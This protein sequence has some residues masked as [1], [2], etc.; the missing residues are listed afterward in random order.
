MS[1]N[2][3]F[4][5]NPA[6]AGQMI[7]GGQ[8]NYEIGSNLAFVRE[9]F[10]AT[11][12]DTDE[13]FTQI[14]GSAATGAS[15]AIYLSAGNLCMELAAATGGQLRVCSKRNFAIPFR[16]IAYISA[17]SGWGGTGSEFLFQVRDTAAIVPGAISNPTYAARFRILGTAGGTLTT[18]AM[19]VRA[20]GTAAGFV[21]PTTSAIDLTAATGCSV[22]TKLGIGIDVDYSGISF[23]TIGTAGYQITAGNAALSPPPT[24]LQHVVSP[25]LKLNQKYAVE[26]VYSAGSSGVENQNATATASAGLVRVFMAEIRQYAPAASLQRPGPAIVYP[27]GYSTAGAAA[28]NTTHSALGLVNNFLKWY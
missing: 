21:A 3:K 5:R 2:N 18:G 22:G 1:L 26:F 8:E 13:W 16:A 12:I 6:G 23:F 4:V 15:A 11:T 25:N 28:Y 24:I 10:N 19:E 14:S 7:G 9:D 20:G 27:M 17:T